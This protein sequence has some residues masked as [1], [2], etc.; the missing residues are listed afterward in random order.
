MYLA[1]RKICLCFYLPR[2][3]ITRS[4]EQIIKSKKKQEGLS[5]MS[6]EANESRAR[7]LDT[8][9]IVFL[10]SFLILFPE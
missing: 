9:L 1:L 4:T 5:N 10:L 6:K 3:S 8:L 7:S 2:E